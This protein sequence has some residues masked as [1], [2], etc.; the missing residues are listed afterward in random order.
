MSSST[1]G[2]A[3]LAMAIAVY[4]CYRAILPRPLPGIPY[5]EASANRIF[6]DVTDLLKHRAEHGDTFGHLAKMAGEMKEPVFQIF[7]QP[8]GRP[9]VIVNDY[10]EAYD[11]MT[12]RFKDF[13]RSTFFG[14]VFRTLVPNTH[15]HFPTGDEWHAHRRLISD[16]MSPRFLDQVAAP[17]MYHT[18]LTMV[19]LWREKARLAAGRPFAAEEAVH[20]TALDITWAATFGGGIGPNQTHTK[21]LADRSKLDLSS[22]FDEPVTFPEA[23]L[24]AAFKSIITLI[25]SMSI[26][27]NSS[28]PALSH[29]V[30]LNTRPTLISARKTKTSLILSKLKD[31]SERLSKQEN[32]DPES[33]A[34][35]KCAMDMIVSKEIKMARKQGRPAE[36]FSQTIQDELLTFLAAGGDTT[37][38]TLCWAFKFFTADQEI[39]SKFR[40]V[41]RSSFRRAAEAN[42]LPTIEEITSTSIPY[43]DAVIEECPR[44]GIIAPTII[45]KALRD[46]EILGYHIPKGTDVF[47]CNNGPGFV[48]EPLH[49]DEHKRSQSSQAGKD[50]IPAWH[51]DP[52]RFLPE[53]WLDE[54]GSF[55]QYA[56]PF[57]SFGGGPRGCFGK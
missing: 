7:V 47:L 29:W 21:L 4:L 42:D 28:T 5:K 9:W 18:M 13:D 39:Q 48:S 23:E 30:A 15:A 49:F 37:S 6:G 22:D 36:L 51:D 45:R 1:I 16:T 24:P 31:A 19:D 52:S 50:K 8:I 25:K 32:H 55:N 44:L 3:A 2:F 17:E 27:M 20:N 56:G 54:D 35:M 53:R 14:Q 11:I 12:R 10:R 57:Q 33:M 34:G 40:N 46:T 43:L 41:L 26:P 38:T